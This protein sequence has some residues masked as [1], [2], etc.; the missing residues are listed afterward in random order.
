M[1]IGFHPI[2][3]ARFPFYEFIKI[4]TL[5]W[6]VSPQTGGAQAIYD[7]MLN[8]FFL[9]HERKIDQ[10]LHYGTEL[11]S[12]KSK[13]LSAFSFDYMK[14]HRSMGLKRH[15][16]AGDRHGARISEILSSEDEN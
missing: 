16:A 7:T 8:P 13:Q 11:L 2:I 1:R 12:E 5:I 9:Q 4:S 10:K 6:L 15:M 3:M 14:M